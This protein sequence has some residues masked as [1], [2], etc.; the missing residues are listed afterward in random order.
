MA[1]TGVNGS[2]AAA[3]GG[4]V[5]FLPGTTTAGGAI[6]GRW[7]ECES[8][9]TVG[10]FTITDGSGTDPGVSCLFLKGNSL[11]VAGWF[12]A[13]GGVAATNIAK[14][15]VV[16][17]TWSAVGDGSELTQVQAIVVD[18][19]TNVY[20][21]LPDPQGVR[22]QVSPMLKMWNGASWVTVGGGLVSSSLTDYLE[23]V[24][25][26]ATDGTNI[27]AGGD[28][29]G[30]YNLGSFVS[31]Y[32]IIKWT[33][34]SWSSIVPDYHYW[35]WNPS[36]GYYDTPYVYSLALCGTNLLAAGDFTGPDNGDGT[37]APPNGVARF[38]AVT[39]ASIP[40]ENLSLYHDLIAPPGSPGIGHSIVVY[41]GA[42]YIGGSFDTVTNIQ[43]SASVSAYGI[44][45]WANSGWSPLGSG[46]YSTYF[47]EPGKGWDL[48][49]DA[50]A[51][52]VTGG[53]DTAGGQPAAGIARWVTSTDTMQ[54][55]VAGQLS[56]GGYH[57]LA[58]KSTG[59][60]W[61]WGANVFGG[62]GD[63]TTTERLTPV[64]V[65]NLAEV[66][67]V[68]AGFGHS[69]ALNYDGTVCAWGYNSN[70]Q[71]GDGTTVNKTV[72]V[73]VPGLTNVVAISAAC[74]SSYALRNDGT[75]W[76]WG[77]N[78][79]GELGDGTTTQRLSPVVV[80]SLVGVTNIGSGC[81]AYHCLAICSNGTV[82]A[83][84]WNNCGQLGDGTTYNRSTP[85][86][87]TNL[88][89]ATAVAAGG[90]HSLALTTGGAVWAWG[91]NGY[92]QLG[93]ALM[94]GD[95]PAPHPAP[96]AS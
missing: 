64:Q 30:A 48:T 22:G 16:T 6:L 71:L 93:N 62:L 83:W 32:S 70:G 55:G 58:A 84:G 67:A 34:T 51:V 82:W 26:L 87:V 47:G 95:F 69:L 41:D 86:Q 73:R 61:A 11:Y 76:A 90:Y 46:L 60:A 39:G 21:A 9:Q 19:A 59:T 85:V 56:A 24:R 94:G 44:A 49:A 66:S 80:P 40:I 12:E 65:K 3:E 53:F 92:G 33:G 35:C 31:S 89:A 50:N 4:G 23:G 18:N 36:G 75:V 27:F 78:S 72:P 10:A 79:F 63:G 38:S 42:V 28:F 91:T 45:Q 17:G 37:F 74:A 52:Y 8:W 2:C 57:T 54:C 7:S 15:D 20:V 81:W 77:N 25:S 96:H 14:Y 1:N 68:S 13:A 43:T 5:L 29:D 88:P